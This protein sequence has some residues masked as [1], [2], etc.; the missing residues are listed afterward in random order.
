MRNYD[1]V[2]ANVPADIER[3]RAHIIGGGLG[4]LATA[5]YLATDGHMPGKHITV[6]EQLHVVGGAMDA[7]GDAERGFTS[8]AERELEARMECLW[9][10]FG[11][12][13]SLI[14]PGRTVLD[15][16]REAN[17]REPIRNKLRLM[18]KCGQK[19]D[20]ESMKLSPDD[21]RAF[22]KLLVT[23]E[24]QIED[25]T[26]K[27]WFTPAFTE[28]NFWY[29]WSTMLA[30]KDYH[31]LIEFRRYLTR[32]IHLV[33]RIEEHR[34]ILHTEFNEFDSMIKPLLVWLQGMGVR[35]ETS[36]E[37]TDIDLDEKTGQITVTGLQIKNAEG[38][39]KL[40]LTADDLVVLTTGSL[41]QNATTG[42]THTVAPINYDT[43]DRGCFTLWEKLAARDRRFGNPA[44]FL[45]DIDKSNWI[46]F[47]VTVKD[48]PTLF[49]YLERLTGNKPGTAGVV[50]IKDSGWLMSYIPYNK[51]YPTQPDTVNVFW[52]Y[53]IYSDRP[54]DFIKKAMRDCTGAEMMQEL[55]YHLG[56]KDQI[57]SILPHCHVATA[58][59]P[60]VTSQFMPR[61]VSDR[62]KVIPDGCTNL[63]LIGQFI[64]IPDDCV[65]TVET[66]V[67][68]G[69]MAAYG[70][71]KLDKPVPPVHQSKYDLRAIVGGLKQMT[72]Q[73]S[74]SAADFPA[75]LLEMLQAELAIPMLNGVPSYPWDGATP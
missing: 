27:D 38:T 26:I 52:A 31:S 32:F 1:R 70:L 19:S 67:R 58:M 66:S 39:R 60:Y 4:G 30:F 10:L 45:G 68:T 2:N 3:K 43:G 49:D 73:Q 24:A 50:T 34:C 9:D 44:K 7:A 48:D 25:L 51:Y 33:E 59:M 74:F 28:T 46:S 64:E 15:E 20:Y 69:M 5:A 12:V 65:F 36:T 11:R 13:P 17:L 56:L 18:E 47:F 54:G 62:P 37:V 55:L 29:C 40:R 16:T 75:E 63:A 41:T 71:L 22:F 53:A 72:D 8:R 35:F 57:D 14:R 42:S 6:Y 61:K 21:T 23:P